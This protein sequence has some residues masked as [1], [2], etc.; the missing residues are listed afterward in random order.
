MSPARPAQPSKCPM[1]VLTLPRYIGLS[2]VRVNP[3][4]NPIAEASPGSP[5]AV[6][7]PESHVRQGKHEGI[8]K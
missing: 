6:P 3:N 8:K 2:G 7:V 5:I 1:L 4:V